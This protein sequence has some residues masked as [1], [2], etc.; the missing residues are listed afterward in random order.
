MITVEYSSNNSGG[1]WWLKDEDWEALA[2]AGWN[3]H[4][5][6]PGGPLGGLKASEYPGPLDPRERTEERWLGALATHAAKEFEDP[7]DAI[8]E[9]ERITGGNAGALGCNCC[10]SPHSFSYTDEEG[11]YHYAHPVEPETASVEWS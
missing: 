1:S 4:W 5:T 8:P 9:W 7:A 6:Q 10:G 2:E 3:V 11:K